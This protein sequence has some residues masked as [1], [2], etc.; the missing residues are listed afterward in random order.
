VAFA[1]STAAKDAGLPTE[2]GISKPG[3]NTEFLSG[4][5]GNVR[6]FSNSD[7]I[8]VSFLQCVSAD[9]HS[10]TPIPFAIACYGTVS[11]NRSSI[12]PSGALAQRYAHGPRSA[13]RIPDPSLAASSQLRAILGPRAL[14]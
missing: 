12:V 9:M 6:M 14:S 3:N 11:A 4:N 13:S 5:N 10:V 2:R 8:F 7:M 1:A